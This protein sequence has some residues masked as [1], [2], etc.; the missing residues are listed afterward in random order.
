MTRVTFSVPL[1]M[2]TVDHIVALAIEAD[3]LGYGAIAL[4]DSVFFPE[5]VSAGYPYTPDGERFWEPDTPFVDPLLAIASMA[6]VT[7]HIEF[8]TNVYKLPLRSPLLAAKEVSSLAVLTGNRFAL[9]VGLAWIPEEFTYT[10]TAK[11]TRGART[12]E[13]IEIVRAVCG[14]GGPQWVEYHGAHYD[15]DKVMVA[16]APDAP[17]R[18]LG[19]GHSDAALAR[20]TRLCDGW[21][22]VQATFDELRRVSSTL[23][24]LRAD[25]PRAD[26]PFQMRVLCTEAFDLDSFRRVAEVPGVTDVQV[27][28]WFFYGGDIEDLN[29]K[30]AALERFRDEV[31]DHLDGQ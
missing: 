22:S 11:S 4:P 3:R 31:M 21:I 7:E 27:L 12:D 16:P 20:A 19:G 1:P 9:G 6:G 24:A 13:A 30:K 23:L 18:I 26:E 29:V 17:V 2:M 28:P 5:E 14:G 15:F 8:Y 25:S 10:G